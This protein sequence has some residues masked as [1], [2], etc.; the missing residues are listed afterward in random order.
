M[1]RETWFQSND[2]VTITVCACGN[3]DTGLIRCNYIIAYVFWNYQILICH[4][5]NKE[6]CIIDTRRIQCCFRTQRMP[7]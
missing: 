6:Y 4:V 3:R 7:C 2:Y 5:A 1:R